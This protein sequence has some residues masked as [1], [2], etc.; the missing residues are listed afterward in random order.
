MKKISIT[1]ALLGSTLLTSVAAF[2]L[3]AA[4]FQEAEVIAA[5][6]G[7]DAAADQGDR[8]VVTGSRIA[9]DSYS[10][11]A[12]LQN[13]NVDSARE[14]GITAVSDL[15]QRTTVA[16]GKQNNL[17]IFT[18]A[19]ASNAT[20]PPPPGGTGS[21]NIGLRG[22][23]PER[24]LVLLNGRRLGPGGIR[25]GPP[26][27]DINLIPFSLVNNITVV[28]EGASAI[29]GADAVAGVVDLQLRNDFEGFEVTG[30][31]TLPEADGGET[32]QVGFIMGGSTDRGHFV[33]GGEYYDQK[34]IL[35][36]DR[37]PCPRSVQEAQNGEIQSFCQQ[38][39]FDNVV[40]TIP[41]PAATGDILGT[42]YTPGETNIGI[43]NFSDGR[44]LIDDIGN[45]ENFT[46]SL[47]PGCD[48]QEQIDINGSADFSCAFPFI[49][50]YSEFDEIMASH[51]VTG[52]ERYSAMAM[53]SY[54]ISD[55]IGGQAE[56]YFEGLFSTR[57][58]KDHK[59]PEQIFPGVAIDI[60]REIRVDDPSSPIL[61]D[62]NMPTGEF[63][64][65]TVVDTDANGIP[66]LV[67]NPLNPF[68]SSMGFGLVAPI[69]TLDQ[70]PQTIEAELNQYRFVGGVRGDIGGGNWFSDNRWSYDIFASYDRNVGFASVPV[71]DSSA[72]ELSQNTLR[73]DPDGNLICGFVPGSSLPPVAG[74]G[75][76]KPRDCVI[77]DFFATNVFEAGFDGALTA[78]EAD[79]L[80]A[81]RL[82]RTVVEQG[83]ISGYFT[84]DLFDMPW[85][86]KKAAVAL[87]GEWRRD[88]IDSQVEILGSK[89]LNAGE[90]QATEGVTAGARNI[91]D[92]YAEILLPVFDNLDIEG[93][94]RFT[95]ESNFGSRETYRTRLKYDLTDWITISGSYG[96]S[97]RAPNLREQFLGDQF[98]S[99][100]DDADPC[101]V[102]DVAL[103]GNTYQPSLDP[104][105]Q[106]VL[107]NCALS[108]ADPTVLGTFA[109]TTIPVRIG[110][111][112][113]DLE[114]ETSRSYTATL[115]MSPPISET[116]DVD[117]AVS[118]FDI[119]VENNIRSVA[120]ETI[121]SR[122]FSDAPGLASPF[123]ERVGARR[124]ILPALDFVS[125][126][127]ASFLN[128]GVEKSQGVD[129]N[130]RFAKEL[131]VV[132]ESPLDFTLTNALT[133]MTKRTEQIFPEDTPD[134]L[135]GD[136]GFPEKKLN[137]TAAFNWA[138]WQFLANARYFDGTG[139]S[140]ATLA[141]ES[142][143]TD[144]SPS[145]NLIGPELTRAVCVADSR[146]YLDL[147]LGKEV[148]QGVRLTA[149]ISNVLDKE[150]PL[151]SGASRA[152]RVNR[153]VS[154]GYDQV[155]RSYFMSIVAS[156]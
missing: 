47:Q 27:P 34:P 50:F 2:A 87:G 20:E 89:A 68:D 123:C 26:Q 33:I 108:G 67:D 94:I 45:P 62:N 30:N 17:D 40:V 96:T 134:S 46:G 71:L 104:R 92:L 84:G 139:A 24:T 83:L 41:G 125:S 37:V 32:K 88:R 81:D 48:V 70:M 28:T 140:T 135:V 23:D 51:L 38:G 7:E 149:G 82:N 13:F 59:P 112:V 138:G 102:P 35:V 101:G 118:F 42:F 100:G 55:I 54:D 18:S 21:A 126:V 4:A 147:S 76:E 117:I 64:Q 57:T 150:P 151:V 133:I 65:I 49:P 154:S 111:A 74:A 113:D 85:S 128:V 106:T 107:D 69:L 148:A 121:L 80:I 60:P 97:F 77:I 9:R 8:I 53:G 114:P 124:G 122:C 120:P 11:P 52:I 6:E 63:N 143:C 25:G 142:A 44:A 144:F 29:Y 130:V 129:I 5:D 105:T 156:F 61:D 75:F 93:A 98:A 43:P 141:A 22:L 86:S 72:L 91:Y 3:P 131:G 103:V 146:W 58:T 115:L 109:G 14:I 39:L 119:K 19:G 153:P 127:D 36:G 152:A 155:G 95:D 137:S 78:E 56:L 10:S 66:I 31:F 99:T 90:N 12:P 16:G 132:G 110:G 79:F 145:T 15:L 73:F 136:F 1:R 116:F